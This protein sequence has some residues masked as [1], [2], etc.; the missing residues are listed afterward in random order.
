MFKAIKPFNWLYSFFVF[1][2]SVFPKPQF[3]GSGPKL[4]VIISEVLKL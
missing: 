4:R 3:S 1:Y 2:E